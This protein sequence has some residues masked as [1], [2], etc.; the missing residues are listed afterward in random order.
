VT[1]A[2]NP[3]QIVIIAGPNGAGKSTLAP[4]LLRDQLGLLEFVNADTIAAGL[5]GFRP[6][7][8]ALEAGRIVLKRMRELAARK[9]SFAFET[10][11][12]TRS[13]ANWLVGLKQDGYQISLLYVWLQNDELARQRVQQ[14]VAAGG[15]DI[16][17]EIIR[18]RY[19]KGVR[20]FFSLYQP[21]ADEWGVYDNSAAGA[22]RLIASGHSTTSQQLILADL[23]AKFCEVT[24]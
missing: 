5:S 13:Y 6:E 12:A 17:A 23:W 1:Q 21:L 20:N 19:S 18:R 15:H 8:A 3:L 11:L 10:T 16:P 22:P 9:Q 4:I 24:R 7:A 2:Q 14:R